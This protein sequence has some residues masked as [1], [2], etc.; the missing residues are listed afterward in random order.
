MILTKYYD[1]NGEYVIHF[2]HDDYDGISKFLGDQYNKSVQFKAVNDLVFG[3]AFEFPVSIKIS[4]KDSIEVR[5]PYEEISNIFD[6]LSEMILL[7]PDFKQPKKQWRKW[8][9]TLLDHGWTEKEWKTELDKR[10]NEKYHIFSE[11]EEEDDFEGITITN[12]SIIRSYWK[13]GRQEQIIAPDK[14]IHFIWENVRL[15]DDV[16]LGRIFDIVENN[17][18][19]WEIITGERIKPII[20]ESKKEFSGSGEL[21]YLEIYWDV[22]HDA[23]YE[24]LTSWPSFHA[25]GEP[26]EDDYLPEGLNGLIYYGISFTPN[27]YLKT[28]KLRLKNVFKIYSSDDFHDKQYFGNKQ[29]K[30]LEMMKAIFYELTWFGT[31]EERIKKHDEIMGDIEEMKDVREKETPSD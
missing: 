17:I 4:P 31:P 28:L 8:N 25:I 14:L 20:E 24:T 13:A 1:P 7:C 6:E 3:E 26:C 12:N 29:F 18:D 19:L 5:T 11:K 16:T 9:E 21:K 27:N 2:A 15:N 30:V 10:L 22:E 23:E